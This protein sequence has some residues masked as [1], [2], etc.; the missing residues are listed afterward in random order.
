MKRPKSALWVLFG[1][2]GA[3]GVLFSS[4]ATFLGVGGDG[5]QVI[6]RATY[7]YDVIGIVVVYT[8]AGTILKIRAIIQAT[9]RYMLISGLFLFLTSIKIFL[10]Y[11][12][13]G[14]VLRCYQGDR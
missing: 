14:V 9:Y 12:P 2:Y 1:F 5:Y 11:I 8:I 4:L 10:K 13:S 3:T 7:E 6:V